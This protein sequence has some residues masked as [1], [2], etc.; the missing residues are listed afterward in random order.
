M[1]KCFE[2]NYPESLG[3]CIVHK[4]PWLFQS[5]WRIIRGWLDPV[6]AAKVHFTNSVEELENFVDKSNIVKEMGGDDPYEYG[7]VEPEE[8]E[9]KRLEDAETRKRLEADRVKIGKEFEKL[10]AEWMATTD[11]AASAELLS[12][13]NEVAARLK[14]GYWELDPYQR[15]RSL[16]DRI[17]VLSQ[18]GKVDWSV[19]VG[20]KSA[21]G[22]AA[23][24]KDG[25]EED[26]GDEDFQDA[27]E[28]GAARVAAGVE[29][30]VSEKAAAANGLSTETNTATATEGGASTVGAGVEEEVADKAAIPSGH[31]LDAGAVNATNGVA[32]MAI[33]EKI[34]APTASTPNTGATKAAA[35]AEEKVSNEAASQPNGPTPASHDPQGVD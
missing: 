19:V 35:G 6:V 34:A 18:D 3:V 12:Q 11:S 27:A 1:I 28:D 24:A 33:E 30:K 7:Y 26:S 9:N 5:I 15:A 29:E 17:G 13:R 16:Y 4:A 8:G 32:S 25:D 20:Q 14:K 10:T 22:K 21:K 23:A 31:A 2:A